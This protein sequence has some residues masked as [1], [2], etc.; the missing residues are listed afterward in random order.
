MKRCR[1]PFFQ[2]CFLHNGNYFC[3][4]HNIF[5]CN[6][7]KEWHSFHSPRGWRASFTFLYQVNESLLSSSFSCRGNIWIKTP[8]DSS[9]RTI[10]QA[11]KPSKQKPARYFPFHFPQ[12][13]HPGVFVWIKYSDDEREI[14]LLKVVTFLEDIPQIFRLHLYP[15]LLFASTHFPN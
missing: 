7:E 10:T 9:L 6:N 12:R 3:F 8:L 14:S 2:V 13:T 11:K 1:D 15:S 4:S 5:K